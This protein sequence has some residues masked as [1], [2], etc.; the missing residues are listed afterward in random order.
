M[1]ATVLQARVGADGVL[2]LEVPLGMELANQMVDVA[3][4]GFKVPETE[5]EKRAVIRSLAGAWQG[6]FER[7]P[8]G[9][10]EKRDP[11]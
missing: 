6:D 7:P 5:D 8:Q 4:A 11:L 3:V 2:R 10:F 1:K 9:E